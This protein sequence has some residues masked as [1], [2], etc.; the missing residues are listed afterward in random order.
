MACGGIELK[1]ARNSGKSCSGLGM[2]NHKSCS[3]FASSYM[4]SDLLPSRCQ[5]TTSTYSRLF[6]S[7][8]FSPPRLCASCLVL[9]LL[10][11]PLFPPICAR[12]LAPDVENLLTNQAIQ[13]LTHSFTFT[14]TP[15]ISLSPLLD[16][17]AHPFSSF[18]PSFPSSIRSTAFLPLFLSSPPSSPPHEQTKTQPTSP[19]AIS[20]K[21][22]TYHASHHMHLTAQATRRRLPILVLKGNQG[23]LRLRCILSLG[24]HGGATFPEAIAAWPD[25]TMSGV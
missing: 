9:L 25:M 7:H 8:T 12:L 11:P 5:W 6:N 14:Y 17:H 2:E 22:F 1:R 15:S 16:Y 23:I 13:S 4:V 18:L 20:H 3:S 21:T 24:S 10:L 19:S